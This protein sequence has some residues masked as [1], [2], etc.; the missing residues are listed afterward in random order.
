MFCK[1][2]NSARPYNDSILTHWYQIG[3]WCWSAP[4]VQVSESVSGRKELPHESYV[5]GGTFQRKAEQKRR[6]NVAN[7]SHE[8]RQKIDTDM[9]GLLSP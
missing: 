6:T 4:K 9:T 3:T 5:E 2:L 1:G 8:L 7:S